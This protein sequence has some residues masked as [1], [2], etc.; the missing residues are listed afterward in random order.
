MR[1]PLPVLAFFLLCA[2][3]SAQKMPWE[4]DSSAAS[5]EGAQ[6][7]SVEYLFPEQ[8]S[9][10]AGKDAVVELHFRVKPGM[11]INSHQ[12]REKGLIP[13]QLIVAEGGPGSGTVDVSA[14]DFPSGGDFSLPSMPSEKLSV[15]TG[16]FVLR[17]H[18]HAN[19]GD[20]MLEAALR[21]QACDDRSCYPPR[22][23]PV[24]VNIMAR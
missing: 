9:V 5:K 20:H 11:H 18:I 8:V 24:A 16:E 22:K 10:P 6:P 3:L 7:Q 12:P 15:Y 23:A 14:V 13:T 19:A 4:S 17:A 2:S 1:S 21:Y